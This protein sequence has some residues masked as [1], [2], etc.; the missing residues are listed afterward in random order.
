MCTEA[1]ASSSGTV[2]SV[3][4]N[5]QSS[6]RF[7]CQTLAHC[8]PSR[9]ICA[10][11]MGYLSTFP[12]AFREMPTKNVTSVVQLFLIID[13]FWLQLVQLIHA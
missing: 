13:P 8:D 2:G 4:W 3:R 11:D 1:E 10:K 12:R 9:E 6:Q 5:V 7:Q